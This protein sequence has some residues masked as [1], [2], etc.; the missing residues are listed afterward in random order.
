M[1]WEFLGKQELRD[2]DTPGKG[3]AYALLLWRTPVPGGWLLMAVNAK[4]SDPQPVISFYPD[5]DHVWQGKEPPEAAYLLR[6]AG[7]GSLSADHLLRPAPAESS[8][9]ER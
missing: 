7:A 4:T 2:S 5:A 8:E 6:P 9:P 1:M 3:Y